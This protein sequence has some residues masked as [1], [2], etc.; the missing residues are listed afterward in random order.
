[1]CSNTHSL[2]STGVMNSSVVHAHFGKTWMMVS[3]LLPKQL[4]TFTNRW[5]RANLIQHSIRSLL[6]RSIFQP[7]VLSVMRLRPGRVLFARRRF[8]QRS[9]VVGNAVCRGRG[10]RTRVRQK[11]AV[12][13]HLPVASLD[14]VILGSSMNDPVVE[15][16]DRISVPKRLL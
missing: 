4:R 16:G 2:T 1:M 9:T 13:R 5:K 11:T 14:R 10:C 12:C 7:F 15:A 3:C 6:M 8:R